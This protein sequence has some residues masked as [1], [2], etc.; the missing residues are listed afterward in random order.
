MKKIPIFMSAATLLLTAQTFNVSTTAELRTA[1]VSAARNGESDTIILADGVYNTNDDGRGTFKYL[2]NEPYDLTLKGSS[3]ENVIL[4]GNGSDQIF[5]FQSTDGAD[6]SVEKITFENGG[7]FDIYGGAIFTF[8]ANI[9]V[10]DCH[11]SNNHAISGGGF[12]IDDQGNTTISNTIFEHNRAYGDENHTGSYNGDGG[13]FFST[14]GNII[15]T[16]SQFIGNSASTYNSYGSYPGNGGGFFGGYDAYDVNIVNSNFINNATDGDGGGFLGSGIQI[17]DS[18][19]TGNAA[20]QY[21]QENT[22]VYGRGG[23]FSGSLLSISNST[24]VNNTAGDTGGG[25]Y[26]DGGESYYGAKISDSIFRGNTTLS[27]TSSFGGAGFYLNVG[28]ISNC[29]ISF[30]NSQSIGGAFVASS[31]FIVNSIITHNISNDEKSSIVGSYLDMAN[32]II[33]YNSSGIEVAAGTVDNPRVFN[34]NVFLTDDDSIISA[35]AD[36]DPI[37]SLKN[38]YIN[39]NMVEVSNFPSNNIH[40]GVNLGFEDASNDNY[41]LTESSDLRDAGTSEDIDIFTKDGVNYLEKDHDGNNRKQG[42]AIDIGA[43]E[44]PVPVSFAITSVYFLL[45]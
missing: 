35:Y 2:D 36:Y 45:M 39:L 9:D 23:G 21:N 19:F 1:L 25:F 17:T 38:N 14:Y 32:N 27:S 10:K 11:F 29:D 24:F 3:R 6:L 40:D 43:Y 34:N 37:V 42:S 4:S 7:N 5:E 22:D 13:G 33:A 16:N 41:K 44:Y 15:I 18:N 30:N 26:D 20:Y 28:I 31:G 12:Y 8:H